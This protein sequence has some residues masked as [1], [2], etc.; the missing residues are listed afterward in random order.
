MNGDA[1]A[2]PAGFTTRP[3]RPS[4]AA[5][6][7]EVIAA[8]Q[9]HHLGRAETT[10]AHVEADWGGADLD[11]HSVLVEDADGRVV[12]AGDAVP[13]RAEL[14]MAYGYVHP[15]FLGRGLGTFLVGF[16]EE[17]ARRLGAPAGAPARVRHYLPEANTSARSLLEARGYGVVRA[18][19]RMERELDAPPPAPRRPPGVTVRAYRGAADEPAAYEA[20]ELGSSGM[21]GRPGND[22]EQ[23]APRAASYDPTLFKLAE[24]DGEI[25]GIAISEAPAGGSDRSGHL[26]SLRVVPEWRRR[27]LGAALI[28]DAF[29]DLYARGARSVALTVDSDSPSGA[30]DLYLAAG[31]RVTRRYLVL[32]RADPEPGGPATEDGVG[33]P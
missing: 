18:I 19:L 9:A 23:W 2:P 5:A 32:E 20:F 29:V 13:S 7:A 10:A 1:P 25:V 31:M 22:F 24:A 16:F 4:D 11:E 6:V 26:E 30:P 14:L 8:D 27:G 12:A 21:W 3:A 33:Y 17:R 28:A 15:E